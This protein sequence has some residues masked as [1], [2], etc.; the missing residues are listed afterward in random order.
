MRPLFSFLYPTEAIFKLVHLQKAG[1]KCFLKIH[2][3]HKS[4]TG[5]SQWRAFSGHLAG[6]SCQEMETWEGIKGMTDR[7]SD[8]WQA[9]A[10]RPLNS[11]QFSVTS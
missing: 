7:Q 6:I 2:I 5:T 3:F 11:Q 10:K 4:F 8:T 9:V 1:C